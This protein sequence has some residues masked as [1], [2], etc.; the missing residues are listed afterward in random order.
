MLKLQSSLVLSC[1]LRPSAF[2]SCR[3]SL[4]F[5]EPGAAVF[6]N[7]LLDYSY[8]SLALW[9]FSSTLYCHL[10]CMRR[11]SPLTRRGCSSFALF[12]SSRLASSCLVSHSSDIL[13][14]ACSSPPQYCLMVS[15]CCYYC[16]RVPPFLLR[17]GRRSSLRY[18]SVTELFSIAS[19]G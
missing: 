6:T 12:L 14:A 10:L 11:R 19:N 13:L 8:L 7:V 16:G 5:F 3:Q 15:V 17:F 1:A 2:L 4:I 9:L 18:C